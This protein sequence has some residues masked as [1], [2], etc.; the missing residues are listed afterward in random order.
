M[1]LQNNNWRGK[2]LSARIL[3]SAS[4]VAQ[5]IWIECGAD[6]LLVDAGDGTL[7]DLL[8]NELHPQLLLGIVIT[9]GHYDHIG[10]LHTLLG[11]MRKTVRQAPL[12]IIAPPDSLELLGAV[13]NFQRFYAGTIPYEISVHDLADQASTEIGPFTIKAHAVVHCASTMDGKILPA[14]PTNGYRISCRGETVAIT[15]DTGR[16]A[17]LEPLLADADLAIIDAA[18]ETSSARSEEELRR[19][20]LCEADAHKLGELAG[21]YIL[22]HKRLGLK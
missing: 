22:V 15:G 8:G 18:F 19:V 5:Q 10:G 14:V 17:N 7:R 20:H 21:Q 9:H 13:D 2:Q 1:E 12:P 6:A 11:F 3:F 4:G 16:A